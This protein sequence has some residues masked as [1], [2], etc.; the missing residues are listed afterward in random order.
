[1]KKVLIIILCVLL[2][3]GAGVFAYFYF[4]LGADDSAKPTVAVNNE[5][6]SSEDE[7]MDEDM[8]SQD[9]LDGEAFEVGSD[10]DVDDFVPSDEYLE[11][12]ADDV[13]FCDFKICR[14]VDHTTSEEV[15]GRVVFGSGFNE[16]DSYIKFDND[17]NFEMFLSDYLNKTK[18]GNFT[19]HDSLIYVEY[20]DGT[21]AEYDIVYNDEGIISYI[22]VNYGDY[23]IYFA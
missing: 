17:G 7:Y 14:I 12:N 13:I 6:L 4:D 19:E 15:K 23:D 2:L 11:D 10:D 18:R 16:A 21:A 22:I 8:S 5:T 1:M 3:I 20:E 9:V